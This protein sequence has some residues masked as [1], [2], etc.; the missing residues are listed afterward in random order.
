MQGRTL[1]TPP[2]NQQVD[3]NTVIDISHESLMRIWETLRDWVQ[4]ESDS[5]K[6]YQRLAEAGAMYQ[7]GR[8]GLWRNPE[9]AVAIAWQE[10]QQPTYAWAQRH[11]VSF[12]RAMGFLQD[13]KEAYEKEQRAK[14][15]AQKNRTKRNKFF[16][17]VL[18][19]ATIVSIA[20][21]VY[22][23]LQAT[24]AKENLAKAEKETIR[25]NKEAEFARTET[26]RAEGSA[27]RAREAAER[28][29][30]SEERAKEKE[31]E[32]IVALEK[33][34][35]SELEARKQETL[36]REN[37]RLAKN[38]QN[39]SETERKRAEENA[40]IASRER[41]K[42]ETNAKEAERLRYKA[43]AQTLAVKSL[44]LRDTSLKAKMAL[45]GYDFNS[46]YN[47]NELNP[48][49]YS[50]LHYAQKLLSGSEFN[51]FHGHR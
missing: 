43:L 14:L 31:K 33:A 6:M 27:E 45:Q 38:A 30:I 48:D 47:N 36:A 7:L 18:A 15:R 26:I 37:A 35:I 16:A 21:W 12:E 24:K 13:S 17:G 51:Q 20:F 32:A 2:L 1:L 40:E 41:E 10:N 50:G 49:I 8:T 25:A 3:F 46:E 4:E 9:L 23:G 39:A 28:A 22:A 42:A 44:Q 11:D 29:K 5:V 19:I 34:R